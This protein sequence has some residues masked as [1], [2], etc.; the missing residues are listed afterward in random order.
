M[1]LTVQVL[2]L[3]FPVTY[4][5][6][7][8]AWESFQS[9]EYSRLGADD[10]EAAEVMFDEDE[11]DIRDT[12][13]KPLNDVYL[14]PAE[15]W[16]L[17]RPLVLRYMAPLFFVYVEE[18]LINSGVAPTLV[19]PMPTSGPWSLLFKKPR[20]YY[21]FWSLTYIRVHLALIAVDGS[22]S[23]PEEAR[24]FIFSTPEYTPPHPEPSSGV[25]RAITAV[26]LLTC[27]EGLCGGSAYV[28]T[29][30]HVGHEGDDAEDPESGPEEQ[31]RKME[32]EFRIGATGAAD[33]T[34]EL[35]EGKNN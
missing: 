20:D 17:F 27:L 32:K 34:G 24:S 4:L 33:S 9:V 35:D 7:L 18:Y 21:P 11:P 1:K 2:P 15:K 13:T 14:T 23:D 31:K 22:S 16:A 10:A 26:F 6:L 19:F 25:D 3:F 29:F 12:S 28:T 5:Y 30:Y 8:P